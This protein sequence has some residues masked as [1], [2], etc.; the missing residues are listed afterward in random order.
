MAQ[1]TILK[2]IQTVA[3]ELNLP[4]PNVA[5]SAN[6]QNIS[7]LIALVR[8]TCDVLLSEYDWQFLQTRYTF[9][10]TQGQTDYP[11]PS[12]ID[13]F[14]SNTSYDTASRRMLVGSLTPQ[15]WEYLQATNSGTNP[16]QMYRVW[17]NVIAFN[18]APGAAAINVAMEYISKN[19]V[20]DGGTGNAKDDFTQDSDIC[21]FDSRVVVFGT[22]YRWLASI[23]QDTTAALVDY[24]RAYEMA[25]GSDTP[26]QRLNLLGGR[27]LH[28][29][30]GANIPEGTWNA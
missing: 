29:L 22:K 19:Y 5:V 23:N 25:K 11:L 4:V 26:S 21:R 20:I 18:P 28:L 2:I 6:D 24:R 9:S 8:A 17:N 15:Q 1:K 16:T 3:S 30:S 13:R 14:L 12:D 27:R 7:K 10:T